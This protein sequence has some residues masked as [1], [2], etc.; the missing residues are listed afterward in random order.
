MVLG[1]GKGAPSYPPGAAEPV[2]QV[3][4]VALDRV[5]AHA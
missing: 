2:E 4:E 3:V 5:L 1:L